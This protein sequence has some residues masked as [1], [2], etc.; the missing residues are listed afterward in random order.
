[1]QLRE[2]L[3][4]LYGVSGENMTIQNEA[5]RLFFAVS[6]LILVGMLTAPSGA[7]LSNRNPEEISP[8]KLMTMDKK[9]P[10]KSKTSLKLA[11]RRPARKLLAKKG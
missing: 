11:D 9:A 1:M 10:A 3:E 6:A 4:S 7:S 2:V 8:S 5:A